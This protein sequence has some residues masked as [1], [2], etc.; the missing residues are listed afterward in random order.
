MKGPGSVSGR[1]TSTLTSPQPQLQSP[2]SGIV[3]GSTGPG[4]GDHLVVSSNVDFILLLFTNSL[5]LI[6]INRFVY[7]PLLTI[8]G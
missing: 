2:T 6:L 7:F 5:T 1:S 3:A 8:N 4:G